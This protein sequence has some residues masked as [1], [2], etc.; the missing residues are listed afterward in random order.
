MENRVSVYVY[1]RYNF[2]AIQKN[3]ICKVAETMP[4][5]EFYISEFTF[6]NKNQ[7]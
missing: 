6:P 2:Q 3:L 1:L 7:D 4:E 5:V